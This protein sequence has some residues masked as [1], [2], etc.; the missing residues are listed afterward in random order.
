MWA[1]R[2]LWTRKS[3]TCVYTYHTLMSLS[4]SGESVHKEPVTSTQL[5][6]RIWHPDCWTLETT[7]SADA[8]MV[9]HGVYVV[10]GLINARVTAYGDS[11]AAVE[12]LIE[13]IETSS[14]TRSVQRI[15]QTFEPRGRKV[16][17]GNTTENLIV[18]YD[19]ENSIHDALVRRGFVPAEPIRIHGGREYWTVIT[20]GPRSALRS[21]LEEIE[22]EMEAE[23]SIQSTGP[24]RSKDWATVLGD[25]LSQRQREVIELARRSGYYAWPRESSAADL[26]AE[27]DISKTT[28]LEHLRKA[29]SKVLGMK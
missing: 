13:E 27:L 6:L 24:A 17:E 15:T 22:Q 4:D 11:I 7:E 14:H 16:T 29:E 10:D 19:E 9:A 1:Q 26:A 18:R 5:V 8:G 28:L 3:Y 21:N 12:T 2:G 25:D 20:N 23:I